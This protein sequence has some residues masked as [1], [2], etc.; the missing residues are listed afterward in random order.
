MN[1][2]LP[3]SLRR[4]YLFEKVS[5]KTTPPKEPLLRQSALL[6]RRTKKTSFLEEPMNLP[7]KEQESEKHKT[8]SSINR[9]DYIIVTLGLL[10][11]PALALGADSYGTEV[12]KGE[13]ENL[14]TFLFGPVLRIAG[15]VGS[16]FGIVRSF[17]TQS[18]QPIFIFRGI[19]AATIIVP[20]LLN[21]MFKV[22]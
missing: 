22:T 19:G 1:G 9:N 7:L 18:L 17:Q 16:V 2:V 20:K 8:S 6:L 11:I 21:V 5:W 3:S 4:K 10:M 13:A 14:Q 15:V 12:L